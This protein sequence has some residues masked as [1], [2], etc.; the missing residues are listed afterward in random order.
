MLAVVHNRLFWVCGVW[1]RQL[2]MTA[3]KPERCLLG[4]R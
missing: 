3:G 1:Q 4:V 2:V